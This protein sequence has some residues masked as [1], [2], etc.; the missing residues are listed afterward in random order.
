MAGML[1]NHRPEFRRC[2]RD[3]VVELPAGAFEPRGPGM[4][5]ALPRSA[6]SRVRPLRRRAT[7]P[8]IRLVD[9]FSRSEH[10]TGG[11]STRSRGDIDDAVLAVRERS[12][13]SYALLP[14]GYPMGRFGHYAAASI[15]SS[16]SRLVPGAG[17]PARYLGATCR[18]SGKPVPVFWIIFWLSATNVSRRPFS[19]TLT[20]K[21]EFGSSATTKEFVPMKGRRSFKFPFKA[22]GNGNGG[23]IASE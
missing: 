4:D 17:L 2:F 13:H 7:N 11:E 18:P 23:R 16:R 22:E 12:V 10:A 15:L 1:V 19:A 5:R 6:A 21:A 9:L 20:G 8:H 14:I 3:V